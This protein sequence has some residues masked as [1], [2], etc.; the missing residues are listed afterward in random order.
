MEPAETPELKIDLIQIAEAPI[1]A[2]VTVMKSFERTV[3]T[4]VEG[5]Q[6]VCIIIPNVAEGRLGTG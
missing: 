3:N 2:R 5:K 4:Y 1:I 6:G